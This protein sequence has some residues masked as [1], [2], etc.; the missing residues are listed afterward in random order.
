MMMHESKLKAGLLRLN[1]DFIFDLPGRRLDLT[2]PNIER[3]QNIRLGIKHIGSM[4]R[5]H[6]PEADV[7]KYEALSNKPLRVWRIGWRTTL[8][9]ISRHHVAGL[10]WSD[11][12]REFSIHRTER[13]I[14]FVEPDDDSRIV[15]VER[16][17]QIDGWI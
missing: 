11:F 16:S 12:E 6:I 5:G 3:W 17:R 9:A 10:A 7:W 13:K 14:V 1:R 15:P 4:D 2:H 8:E